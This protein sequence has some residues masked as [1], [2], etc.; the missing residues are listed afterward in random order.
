MLQNL[1]LSL[2][3]NNIQKFFSSDKPFLQKLKSS[4]S[5]SGKVMG[6]VDQDELQ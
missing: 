5:A 2:F 6:T 3:Y 4:I 1:I